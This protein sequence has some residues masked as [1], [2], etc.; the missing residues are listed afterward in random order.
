MTIADFD[1]DGKP[2]IVVNDNGTGKVYANTLSS[3][4]ANVV[5]GTF[6]VSAST[7]SSGSHMQAADLDGDG[8][9]DVIADTY[10]FPGTGTSPG[11]ISFGTFSYSYVSNVKRILVN[12]DFNL[13]GKGRSGHVEFQQSNCSF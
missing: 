1:K 9:Q 6:T 12:H 11:P 8:I 3:A 13:D 2:D 5:A 4:G 10:I 7:L